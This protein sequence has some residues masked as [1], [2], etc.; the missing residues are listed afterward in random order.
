MEK[1]LSSCIA[2]QKVFKNTLC[3]CH[4]VIMHYF[5]LCTEKTA[6]FCISLHK[7]QMFFLAAG[8]RFQLCLTLLCTERRQRNNALG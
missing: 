7:I 4:P 1:R 5:I 8:E 6:A 3:L 2:V